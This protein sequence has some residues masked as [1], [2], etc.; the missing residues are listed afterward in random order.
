MVDKAA[1]K[2][3]KLMLKPVTIKTGIADTSHT[4]VLDGLN[5]GD[6]VVTSIMNPNTATAAPA[7]QPGRSPFGGGGFGGG[8]RGG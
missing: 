3:D 2:P 1:S 6:E 4:E 8:R 5:D 7:T